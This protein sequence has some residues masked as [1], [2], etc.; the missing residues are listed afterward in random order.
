MEREKAKSGKGK[1]TGGGGVWRKL[2]TRFQESLSLGG[3][4]HQ[5]M[6]PPHSGQEPHVARGSSAAARVNPLRGAL[7]GA[8]GASLA[9]QMVKSLLAVWETRV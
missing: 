9:A 5:N 8:R 1:G 6:L 2:G 4:G 7:S 3:K